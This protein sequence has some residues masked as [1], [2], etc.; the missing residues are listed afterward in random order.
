MFDSKSLRGIFV[1][2]E[3][4]LGANLLVKSLFGAT[5]VKYQTQ[6]LAYHFTTTSILGILLLLTTVAL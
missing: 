6:L 1:R 5:S 4:I 3:H 2:F